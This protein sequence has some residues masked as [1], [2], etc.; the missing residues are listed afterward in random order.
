MSFLNKISSKY[1]SWKDRRFLKKHGVDSWAQY[2]RRYDPDY[3]SRADK[4]K[5]YYHGYK[6]LV[7]FTSAR[8]DPF[9]RFGTWME[10]LDSITEWCK[11]NCQDKWRHDIMRVYKQTA[12]GFD[13]DS[14]EEWWINDIGGGD[15]LFF[16]FKDE[17]DAFLFKLTWGCN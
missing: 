2:H 1:N 16:A 12:L 3:N 17:Q 7:Q 14:E 15:V 10:G 11:N 6:C 5:D 13:G 8:T 9:I 4:V